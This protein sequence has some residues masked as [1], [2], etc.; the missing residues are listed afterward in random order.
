MFDVF[1]LSAEGAQ[2]GPAKELCLRFV[3]LRDSS[4][5]FNADR[6]LVQGH[7][8]LRLPQANG[9]AILDFYVAL[10]PGRHLG[11]LAATSPPV[12][13]PVDKGPVTAAKVPKEHVGRM[14]LKKKVMLREISILAKT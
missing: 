13:Y 4:A 11:A 3:L 2:V 7:C 1:P 12:T 5:T 14:N 10:A 6:G 8:E 9:V